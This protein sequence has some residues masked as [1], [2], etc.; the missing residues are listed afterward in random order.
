[1]ESTQ[2]LTAQDR[3]GGKGGKAKHTNQRGRRAGAKERERRETERERGVAEERGGEAR[4]REETEMAEEGMPP[5]AAGWSVEEVAAW[6]LTLEGIDDVEA[7]AVKV[8]TEEVDGFAMMAYKDRLEVRSELSLSGGKAA[9]LFAAIEQLRAAPAKP[10]AKAGGTA[11]IVYVIHGPGSEIWTHA[12]SLL[13]NTW[14]KHGLHEF[15]RLIEVKEIQNAQMRDRYEAFKAGMR[16]GVVNGNEM[17]VF[18]GCGVD[19]I[20]SIAEKGFL[21]S[22]QNTA[23]WQRFGPGF[24]FAL[25]VGFRV[26]LSLSLFLSSLLARSGH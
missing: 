15:L 23:A 20:E 14:M 21:K 26:C 4:D 3:V 5:L 11:P 17:L 9:R 8:R 2:L 1:M 19:A 16:E 13:Q 7:L 18:H 24:Y 12:D 25:Q 10:A 6:V 22:F